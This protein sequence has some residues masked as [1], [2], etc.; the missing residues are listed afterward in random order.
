MRNA[1]L[2]GGHCPHPSAFHPAKPG[3]KS[4]SKE[5]KDLKLLEDL[6]LF[7]PAHQPISP[8]AN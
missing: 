3:G 5:L 8:S 1:E 4:A 7:I 6:K 2:S